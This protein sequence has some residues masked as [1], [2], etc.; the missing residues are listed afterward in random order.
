M[1]TPISEQNDGDGGQC[2]SSWRHGSRVLPVSS[3][4]VGAE[5]VRDIERLDL[6][7]QGRPK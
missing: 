5:E 3:I 7:E 6:R 2:A 4:A 1:P